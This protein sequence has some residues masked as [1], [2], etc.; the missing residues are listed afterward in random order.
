MRLRLRR[1]HRVERAHVVQP[2]GELDQDDA[3]VARHRQQH[4]AEVLGLRFLG[5][6]GTRSCRAWRRRRPARRPA[7]RSVRQISALVTRGVL[8]HVVQQRRHQRLGVEVPVG[9]DLG[10]RERMRDVRARPTGADLAR[11]RRVGEAVGLGEARHV[12]RLQVAEAALLEQSGLRLPPWGQINIYA[13]ALGQA[14]AVPTACRQSVAAGGVA[15][16]LQHLGADLAGGDLAQ[17][18]DGRL[19]AVGLDQRARRRR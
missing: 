9:E 18:D 19:V 14:N 10:D 17:R 16:R 15:L 8:D 7:C 12:L 2:V 6:T 4:L 11:V 3:H 13:L 1:R 5:A